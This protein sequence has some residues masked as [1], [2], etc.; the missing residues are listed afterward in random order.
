MDKCFHGYNKNAECPWCAIIKAQAEGKQPVIHQ[1]EPSTVMV[2]DF[3]RSKVGMPTRA[4]RAKLESQIDA[5]IVAVN[6]GL[7]TTEVN[8]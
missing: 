8:Q 5:L 4:D 2:M 6:D 1:K 3:L 7:I